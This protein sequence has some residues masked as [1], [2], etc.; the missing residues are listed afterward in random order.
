MKALFALV[1]LHL[2]QDLKVTGNITVTGTV[3]GV[4]IATRDAN[5]TT[6]EGYLD[7][8]VKTTSNPTL[9]FQFL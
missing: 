2:K 3:D 4:D 9:S 8:E 6:V 1:V 5:L 7:Q